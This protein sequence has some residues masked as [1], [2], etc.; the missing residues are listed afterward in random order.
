MSLN[1][2]DRRS[3]PR[4][5]WADTDPMLRVPQSPRRGSVFARRRVVLAAVLLVALVGAV[6]AFRRGEVQ[7][8]DF[9][10]ER[11]SAQWAR[12]HYGNPDAR[13]FKR[14]N[15][16]S[17]DFLG[18]TMLVHEDS[19]R[20]FLRLERLF[21][22]RAPEYAARVALGEIDDWSYLN[23]NVRG[24]SVKSNHSFGIAIDVNALANPLGT[25]GDIPANV[26]QQWRTEGGA[27][28]GDW[29]RSDPMHFETHLT[30]E[31]IRE[32]YRADGT[33]RDA[34]LKELIGG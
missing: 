3:D 29:R 1:D 30:P 26:V 24:E 10:P 31:E 19:R 27:W 12:E 16:V 32:R 20:H 23:R 22:A 11:G 18:R 7:I 5:E 25:K 28:G 13:G 6:L 34:Y 4:L 15:I 2:V 21:E 33:P 17:I 8:V 14:R 9:G